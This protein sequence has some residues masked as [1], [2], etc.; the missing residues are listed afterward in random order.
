MLC[1]HA[2][3]HNDKVWGIN[4]TTREMPPPKFG[5]DMYIESKNNGVAEKKQEGGVHSTNR[6]RGAV[7]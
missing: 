3:T 2:C 4:K 5:L 7:C 1:G 6:Q